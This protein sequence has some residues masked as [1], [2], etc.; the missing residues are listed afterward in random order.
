MAL[1]GTNADDVNLVAEGRVLVPNKAAPLLITD[2]A[3]PAVLCLNYASV[4]QKQL[5]SGG[6]PGHHFVFGTN[7]VVTTGVPHL[8]KFEVDDDYIVFAVKLSGKFTY[9]YAASVPKLLGWFKNP[10]ARSEVIAETS[11]LRSIRLP[12]KDLLELKPVTN[13]DTHKLKDIADHF[14]SFMPTFKNLNIRNASHCVIW[15]KKGFRDTMSKVLLAMEKSERTTARDRGARANDEA[16]SAAGGQVAAAR[17]GL[18]KSSMDDAEKYYRDRLEARLIEIAIDESGKVVPEKLAEL[19]RELECAHAHGHTHIHVHP[20]PARALTS[21]RI[22]LFLHACRDDEF[23]VSLKKALDEAVADYADGV[24][25]ADVALPFASPFA[26]L[27]KKPTETG[28]LPS[29]VAAA[30]SG[31]PV[32]AATRAGAAPPTVAVAEEVV[33]EVTPTDEESDGE[34]GGRGGTARGGRGRPK[35][36]KNKDK[37]A[38]GDDGPPQKKPKSGPTGAITKKQFDTVVK[39]RDVLQKEKDTLKKEKDSLEKKNSDLTK[40]LKDA[41]TAQKKAEEGQKAAEKERDELTAV[42]ITK[43]K[44]VVAET[45][46]T[47]GFLMLQ[48]FERYQQNPNAGAAS[49]SSGTAGTPATPSDNTSSTPALP[50]PP[51]EA[52]ASFFKV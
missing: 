18:L 1:S 48:Q 22:I 36:S 9:L 12:D 5:Y 14:M 44:L 6:V 19:Y 43:E 24:D 4:V 20:L 41:Q 26:S 37:R 13:T 46:M 10:P 29:P 11:M 35:G 28:T 45:K 33:A 32:R 34:D 38:D 39:E 3:N 23:A 52:L 42:Q 2:D 25:R 30:G 17:W 49:S 31:R 27:L 50:P 15:A 7:S 51:M 8:A 40:N 47:A 16:E 21:T